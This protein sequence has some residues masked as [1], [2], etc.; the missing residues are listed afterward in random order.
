MFDGDKNNCG[1][2]P[3]S[4]DDDSRVYVSEIT[5]PEFDIIFDITRTPYACRQTGKNLGEN[6]R[7]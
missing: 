6:Q 2:K 1:G 3:G 5:G 7:A 4:S